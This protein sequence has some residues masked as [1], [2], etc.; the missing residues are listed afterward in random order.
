MQYSCQSG[1]YAINGSRKK[2]E[3]TKQLRSDR[4]SVESGRYNQQVVFFTSEEPDQLATGVEGVNH[5]VV[6]FG[7]DRL[8]RPNIVE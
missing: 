5:T 2:V 8:L 7:A 3:P 4:R 6:D 1:G